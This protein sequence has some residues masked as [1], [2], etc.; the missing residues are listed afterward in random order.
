MKLDMTSLDAVRGRPDRLAA[1]LEGVSLALAACGI[2]A[3]AL[4]SV[5]KLAEVIS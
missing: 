5:W 3:A 1:V 2:V 4:W